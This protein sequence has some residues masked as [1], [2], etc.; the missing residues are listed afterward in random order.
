MGL[1]RVELPIS[2]LSGV[3]S[4]LEAVRALSQGPNRSAVLKMYHQRTGAEPTDTAN[5]H[6]RRIDKIP[7]QR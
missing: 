5:R 4:C 3:R 6:L 2:R 1:G 7:H